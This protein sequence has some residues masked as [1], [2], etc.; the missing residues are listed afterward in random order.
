MRSRS[1]SRLRALVRVIVREPSVLHRMRPALVFAAVGQ[2]RAD[3]AL[4]SQEEKVDLV[5]DAFRV[6]AAERDDE[7]RVARPM[8][9]AATA[10]CCA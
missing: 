10:G 8:E 6:G 5:G 7:R 2:G 9:A 4:D 1:P 3:G